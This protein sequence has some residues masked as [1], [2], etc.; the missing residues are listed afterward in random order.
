VITQS[1]YRQSLNYECYKESVMFEPEN[2]QT[3]PLVCTMNQKLVKSFVFMLL[4][5]TQ[6]LGHGVYGNRAAAIGD[7]LQSMLLRKC[8]EVPWTMSEQSL[9]H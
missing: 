8:N 9:E 1:F 2:T 4:G 6:L 5:C 3:R 7:G